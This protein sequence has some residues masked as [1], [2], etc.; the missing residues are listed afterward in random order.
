[1]LA[2][3][4]LLTRRSKAAMSPVRKRKRVTYKT[5]DGHCDCPDEDNQKQP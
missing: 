1:M 5:E 3:H 2:F 4:G